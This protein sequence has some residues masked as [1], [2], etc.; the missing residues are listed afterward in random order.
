M[1][2]FTGLLSNLPASTKPYKL[3]GCEVKRFFFLGGGLSNISTNILISSFN[4]VAHITLC[5]DES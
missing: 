5:S 1:S 2:E 4:E 3:K